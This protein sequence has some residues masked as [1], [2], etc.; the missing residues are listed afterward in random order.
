MIL[1]DAAVAMILAVF[2]AMNTA[3]KHANC[4]LPEVEGKITWSSLYR[5]L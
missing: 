5:F 3:Q 1:D 2:L 4:R